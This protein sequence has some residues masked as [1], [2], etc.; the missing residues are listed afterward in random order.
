[1][2]KVKVKFLPLQQVVE[3]DSGTKILVVAR[4][5]KINIRFGCGACRCGTCAIALQTSG[6]VSDMAAD[7][8][9]LLDKMK[10]PLDGTVRLA[11]RT[12]VMKGEAQVDLDFQDTYSPADYL[13]EEYEENPEIE[14]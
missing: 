3:A 2:E 9:A 12:K 4:R 1:L 5:A 13:Y 14:E 8:R 11:C 7:E 6:E 10:L